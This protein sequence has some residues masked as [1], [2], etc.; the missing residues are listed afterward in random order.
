MSFGRDYKDFV[1]ALHVKEGDGTQSLK[2]WVKEQRWKHPMLKEHANLC[3]DNIASFYIGDQIVELQVDGLNVKSLKK[4]LSRLSGYPNV[5]ITNV[6]EPG[7]I[8]PWEV[9]E[10]MKSGAIDVV[11]GH[12]SSLKDVTIIGSPSDQFQPNKFER[13]EQAVTK[14]ITENEDLC[15]ALFE[16][17][18]ESA[19][20]AIQRVITDS[21]DCASAHAVECASA[22]IFKSA[23]DTE[24]VEGDDHHTFVKTTL[25][26]NNRTPFA[27]SIELIGSI[28]KGIVLKGDIPSFEVA[29]KLVVPDLVPPM[30]ELIPLKKQMPAPIPLKRQMPA[31]IPLKNRMPISS[32]FMQR[33]EEYKRRGL[34]TFLDRLNK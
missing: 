2:S 8:L 33:N 28:P 3:E 17:N 25:L 20:P 30:P 12:G 4:E 26:Q 32:D 16:G 23:K 29:N 18:E 27:K 22:L 31:P 9:S 14:G 13:V 7:K 6:H 15:R 34:P 24:K 10:I 21:W 11:D 5:K 19:I 1:K